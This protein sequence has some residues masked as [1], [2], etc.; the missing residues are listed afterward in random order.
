[1]LQATVDQ[2]AR[3]ALLDEARAWDRRSATARRASLDVRAALTGLPDLRRPLE[4]WVPMVFDGPLAVTGREALLDAAAEL[5]RLRSVLE[6][7][8]ARLW[9]DAQRYERQADDLR[10]RAAALTA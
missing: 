2:G 9:A 10:R 8:A 4:R 3:D 5:R 6:D 7:D 1:M